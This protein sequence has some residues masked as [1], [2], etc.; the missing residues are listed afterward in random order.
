[1]MDVIEA[2]KNRYLSRSVD[3]QKL[4]TSMLDEITS[5]TVKKERAGIY[6]GKRSKTPHEKK[7]A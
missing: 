2:S 4:R 1:M 5:K 3:C 7:P 6:R